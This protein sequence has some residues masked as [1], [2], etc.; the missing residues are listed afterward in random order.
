MVYR[1]FI[2]TTTDEKSSD[3]LT[4]VKNALWNL[5]DFPVS[6]IT[7]EE[8]ANTEE[9]PKI[10]IRRILD[11]ADLFIGVYGEDYGQYKDLPVQDLIEYEYDYAQERGIKTLIFMPSK[12][13]AEDKLEA[14][15]DHIK[16]RQIV[17]WFN[18]LDDLSAK[19]VLAVTTHRKH[20]RNRP[21][22]SPP[23]QG[24]IPF[25]RQDR[26]EQSEE[27]FE[28]TVQR[29]FDLIQDELEDIVERAIA[30]QNARTQAEAPDPADH[31][32]HMNVNPIFGQ[33]NKNVQFESDI[34]M[35]TPFRDGYNDIYQRVIVPT[36]QDLNLT[37]KRG[38]EFN[39]V[40]GQIM[41]E[42]WAALNACRLVIVETT[43]INANVYYELGIAHTLGKPAILIT[44]G[45]EI[46]DFPFD[47]RHLRFTVYETTD[48]GLTALEQNLRDSI[49][50][51]MN[52]LEDGL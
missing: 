38:D 31:F 42:V 40:N 50:R 29:A 39:S 41:G 3:Y 30:V 52:D 19:V 28:D 51:I 1:V 21:K 18:N 26:A 46:E 10:V 6:P 32:Y 43:E 22:L 16:R 44:Q 12:S 35:I 4:T 48:D 14:F 7:M 5:E 47:I 49:I 11:D 20:E 27:E 2:S 23:K 25:Q 34:F 24:L 45:K 15:K 37:I 36:I 8:L 13:D 9:D 33:P 17:V